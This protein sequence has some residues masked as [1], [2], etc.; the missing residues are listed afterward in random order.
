MFTAPNLKLLFVSFA[1]VLAGISFF[2]SAVTNFANV[3]RLEELKSQVRSLNTQNQQAI[4]DLAYKKTTDFIEEQARLKLNM[5]KPNEKLYVLAPKYTIDTSTTE[6][7]VSPDSQQVLGQ[8]H[9]VATTTTEP[10]VKATLGSR[11]WFWL[12]HLGAKIK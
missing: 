12:T 11:F 1:L 2:R 5:V 10:S 4:D 6:Q 7:D 8:N 9:V 3:T